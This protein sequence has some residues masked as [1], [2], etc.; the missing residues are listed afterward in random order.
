MNIT[1]LKIRNAK[2]RIKTQYNYLGIIE[3]SEDEKENIGQK[4]KETGIWRYENKAFAS[5]EFHK[6]G[7]IDQELVKIQHRNAQKVFQEQLLRLKCDKLYVLIKENDIFCWVLVD[8]SLL[9]E[10]LEQF[11]EQNGDFSAFSE[12]NFA[13]TIHQAEYE[14]EVLLWKKN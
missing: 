14:W 1:Q 4:F 13:L 3:I 12:N 7:V 6:N 9:C 2:E 5:F 8:F 11:L 10:H